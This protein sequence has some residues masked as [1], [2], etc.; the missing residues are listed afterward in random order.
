[1]MSNK[2]TTVGM[3]NSQVLAYT[4]G[5]D[6]ELDRSL[7]AVDCIGTAAHVTMLAAM[8]VEPP[9]ISTAERDRVIEALNTIRA[10]AEKGS[11]KIRLSDQDVHLAV[12]RVLTSELGDLGKKVHT[13]RSRND[14]VAVDLRLFAKEQL[15]HTLEEVAALAEVLVRFGKKHEGVA[16]VGRTHMQPGM[17]SS[18]GLWATAHAESL[19]DDAAGLFHLLEMNDQSPLGSAASYGVPLPIDRGLTAKLLGFSR[20][21]H[22]VLYANNSRGKLEGLVLGGMSQIM[23]TLSR[24]AQD[25]MIF[26]MPEFDYFKLPPAFCTGSSIM[27]QKQNPDVC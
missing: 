5:R 10:Q 13:G 19:L 3:I 9:V 16:M 4:A 6:V 21:T 11:F 12:E 20:A 27:P 23:L 8:P 17:P 26:T 1:M 2:K 18:V 25:L 14:Q 15:W 22:N 7:V 24:L